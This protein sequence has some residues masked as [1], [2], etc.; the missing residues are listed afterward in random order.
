MILTSNASG[1]IQSPTSVTDGQPV[2]VGRATYTVQRGSAIHNIPEAT[3]PKAH[4][5]EPSG[6]VRTFVPAGEKTNSKSD[7]AAI[8]RKYFAH[9]QIDP[10]TH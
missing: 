6:K 1:Y 3:P 9:V 4:A 10:K 7:Q 5:L 8:R 2:K